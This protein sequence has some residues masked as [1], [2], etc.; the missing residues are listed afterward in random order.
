[1]EREIKKRAQKDAQDILWEDLEDQFENIR[2][3]YRKGVIR[4]N[5]ITVQKSAL[6]L[7]IETYK[8]NVVTHEPKT[9]Q[10]A[11]V[12]KRRARKFKPNK[13]LDVDTVKMETSVDEFLTKTAN[14][15]TSSNQISRPS[16]LFEVQEEIKVMCDDISDSHITDQNMLALELPQS[17]LFKRTAYKTSQNFNKMTP[18]SVNLAADA[19]IFGE[20]K[21]SDSDPNLHK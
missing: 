11:R 7:K 1:M 2:K 12:E 16:K 20:M 21:V 8:S 15:N 9:E 5:H 17:P 6:Y 14:F 4:L 3:S 19:N 18:K 10:Q 13:V